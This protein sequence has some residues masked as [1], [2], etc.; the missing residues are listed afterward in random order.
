VFGRARTPFFSPK[1]S[2]NPTHPPPTSKSPPAF[3]RGYL[4]FLF[5]QPI[6]LCS[7][8]S[9][10]LLRSRREE[11]RPSSFFR[12]TPLFALSLSLPLRVWGIPSFFPG[13]LLDFF[14]LSK[15]LSSATSPLLPLFPR[16]FS[17]V[18][19]SPGL[20]WTDESYAS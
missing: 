17:P 3:F 1:M 12:T 20:G 9:F 13:S 10:A 14:F 11:S 18:V 2:P 15:K 7:S 5:A 6:R 8:L 4:A 19:F 16:F